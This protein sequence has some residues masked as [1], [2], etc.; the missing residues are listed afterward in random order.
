MKCIPLTQGKSAIVDDEDFDSLAG[1]KWRF[2]NSGYAVRSVSLNGHQRLILMHRVIANTPL[3]KWTDHKNG[4]KLDNRRENL[5]HCS[6]SEN[7]FNVGVKKNNQL[8]VKGVWFNKKR[9]RYEV[10]VFLGNGIHKWLGRF[11]SLAAAKKTYSTFSQ[12]AHGEF[13]RIS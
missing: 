12:M 7:K 4:D 10:R 2:L 5:R 6:P 9:N 8:G 13:W 1:F 3:G 11:K